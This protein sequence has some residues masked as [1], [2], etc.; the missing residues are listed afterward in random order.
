MSRLYDHLLP[1]QLQVIQNLQME[2][3]KADYTRRVSAVW[4]WLKWAECDVETVTRISVI[5]L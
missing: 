1:T 4:T 3:G 2:R 5:N